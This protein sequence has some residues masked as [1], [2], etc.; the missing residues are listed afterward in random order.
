MIRSGTKLIIENNNKGYYINGDYN[1]IHPFKIINLKDNFLIKD[2]I[3][4]LLLFHLIKLNS[5]LEYS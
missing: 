5:I 2:K 4:I 1:K 3:L